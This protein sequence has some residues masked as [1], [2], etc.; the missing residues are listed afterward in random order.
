[1]LRFLLLIPLF[2]SL[3]TG[4]GKTKKPAKEVQIPQRPQSSVPKLENLK[5]SKAGQRLVPKI[6]LKK[7][8][9]LLTS[10]KYEEALRLYEEISSLSSLTAE[11]RTRLFAG[12]GEAYLGLKRYEEAVVSWEKVVALRK[13]DPAPYQNI[14]MIYREAKKYHKA[15]ESFRRCLK[16]E[17]HKLDVRLEIVDLLKLMGAPQSE[18]IAAAKELVERR[19]EMVTYLK[20]Q[21]EGANPITISNYLDYL[22]EMPQGTEVG[23]VSLKY[24]AKT[25]AHKSSIIRGKAGV[26]AV[27]TPEGAKKVSRLLLTEKNPQVKK[28][29]RAALAQVGTVP[30]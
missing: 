4:C 22:M 7:A 2:S 19:N 23:G 17:P 20:T 1:M 10:K 11:A 8:E 5:K 27:R 15:L 21:S 3:S 16:I 13:S 14:G 26:L 25:L 24:L 28:E 9:V 29:W 18:Q 12:M 30:R 6:K